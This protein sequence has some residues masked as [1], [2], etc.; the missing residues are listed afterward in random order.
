MPIVIL[1]V[2]VVASIGRTLY[3][4]AWRKRQRG[5]YHGHDSIYGLA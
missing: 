2:L 5:Y 4:R 3:V 1:L